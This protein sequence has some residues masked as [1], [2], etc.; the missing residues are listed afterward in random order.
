MASR[1]MSISTPMQNEGR[2]FTRL[3]GLSGCLVSWCSGIIAVGGDTL[4]GKNNFHC[5][6][7]LFILKSEVEFDFGV[8]DAGGLADASELVSSLPI[9]KGKYI[10]QLR[11]IIM[12][13]MGN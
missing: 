13:S 12:P 3:M 11:K 10:K 8:V 7:R 9:L 1:A 6:S 5:S 2:E 4:C